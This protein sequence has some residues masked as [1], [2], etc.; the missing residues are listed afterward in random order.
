MCNTHSISHYACSAKGKTMVR[1][2]SSNILRLIM[3][4]CFVCLIIS[5]TF[6]Q[7]QAKADRQFE[8][9][10]FNDALKSY[11]ELLKKTPDKLDLLNYRIGECYLQ[12]NYPEEALGWY[13]KAKSLGCKVPELHYS[14]GV[15]YMKLGKYNDALS[16]LQTYAILQPNDDRV[17]AKIASCH[18]AKSNGSVN[19]DFALKPVNTLNTTG[20]EFGIT[21]YKNL[22]IYSSTGAKSKDNQQKISP[23][24]GLGYAA[25]YIAK[26]NADGTFLPGVKLSDEE[27][28]KLNRG[29]VTY[30][31]QNDSFY[32]TTCRNGESECYTSILKIQD[33]QVREV[34]RLKVGNM[35]YG[36]G[37]PFVSNDGSTLFFTSKMEGGFGGNDIWF[38]KRQADGS[39]GSP[40]NAGA[41]VNTTRNEVFPYLY[42]THLF[43]SSNGREGYGGLDLFVAE[44][45]DNGSFSK[46][47]NLRHPFNSE[48]DDFNLVINESGSGGL[49]VSS[50]NDAQKSDDIYQFNGYPCVVTME[51][52]VYDKLLSR[53]LPLAQV[54]LYDGKG[55]LQKRIGVDSLANYHLF[56]KPDASYRVKVIAKGYGP[57]EKNISTNDIPCF[58]AIN[59]T[60]GH[61]V[62]FYLDVL[63]NTSETEVRTSDS[64]FY[65][66]VIAD[67]YYEFNQSRI[68]Q[69]AKTEIDEIVEIL[70]THPYLHVRIESHT[71]S[72]GGDVYNQRLS[73]DRALLMARYIQNKGIAPKRISAIGYGESE[74][75]I[76]NAHSEEEH[77]ANRRTVFTLYPDV[78]LDKSNIKAL[79]ADDLPM[80]KAIQEQLKHDKWWIQVSALRHASQE[81]IAEMEVLTG[82]SIEAIKCDDGWTRLCIGPF[83]VPQQAEEIIST[84]NERG[85]ET[86]LKQIQPS[87]R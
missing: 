81:S 35:E 12:M 32:C 24:T 86:I 57:V 53:P 66:A 80:H 4:T 5:S 68:T 64:I 55:T 84:L 73:E 49:I 19:P 72:R 56:V 85:V 9:G 76:K 83:N 22:L 87:G 29:V 50:R 33:N 58:T 31:K 41:E 27:E 44:L 21:Y 65:S 60:N 79:P 20:S 13:T 52:V 78:A 51:G 59:S 28:G 77:Q 11:Q 14:T 70:K 63:R 40:I 43:F 47:F 3:L 71:D 48:Q 62:N 18:F 10:A 8:Q 46:A 7:N 38:A 30:D 2:I 67:V 42:N 39:W 17:A 36:I 74:L 45:N 6:A 1:L 82:H 15:A 26:Q 54:E 61:D 37:H 23:R 75:L 25:L 69:Q 16:E 34:G